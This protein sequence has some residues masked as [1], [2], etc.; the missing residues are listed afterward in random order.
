MP[1]EVARQKVMADPTAKEMAET[2]G[3]T[4][5]AF[6]D[7]VVEC[8]QH[9]DEIELEVMTPDEEAEFGDEI[10]SEAEVI[11][12]IQAVERGEIDF[13]DLPPNIFGTDMLSSD[14]KELAARRATGDQTAMAAPRA[15]TPRG[16][17]VVDQNDPMGKA[18]KSQLLLQRNRVIGNHAGAGAPSGSKVDS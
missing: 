3:L 4:L 17:V 16:A 8:A 14:V 6:A 1:V 9:P 15:N 12:W 18:L 2:L 7:R 13:S 5:E 11:A 10:P